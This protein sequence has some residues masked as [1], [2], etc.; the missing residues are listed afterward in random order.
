M[1]AALAP[2]HVRRERGEIKERRHRI[3][4]SCDPCH[5]FGVHR[6]QDERHG[7]A[8]GRRPADVRGD[9]RDP[10]HQ[11][12][13]GRVQEKV[14]DVVEHR[15]SCAAE[16]RQLVRERGKWPN[17][18]GDEAP[19]VVHPGADE[20]VRKVPRRLRGQQ[21]HHTEI[22]PNKIIVHRRQVG[23]YCR[24]DHRDQISPPRVFHYLTPLTNRYFRMM[25]II[26]RP[27]TMAPFRL[28][29]ILDSPTRPR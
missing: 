16:R 28:P 4:A 6:Q 8:H 27:V 21:L 7:G 25:P 9:P 2:P 17:L 10:H 15:R 20:P 18:I 24:E 19:D 23:E 29:V 3:H 1:V 11:D 22:V 12:A 26:L 14:Q 13:V 5:A